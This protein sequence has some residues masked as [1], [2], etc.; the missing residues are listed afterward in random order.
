VVGAALASSWERVEA[1]LERYRGAPAQAGSHDLRVGM[2]RFLAAAEFAQL[3]EP[4]ALPDKLPSRVKRLMTALSP[5]RDIEIQR[6]ALEKRDLVPEARQKLALWL[7]Q[8]EQKLAKKVQRRLVRFPVER[9]RQGV[10]EA[11]AAL[12]RPDGDSSRSAELALLGRVAE[13]Y[14]TFDR[15]RRASH[16]HDLHEL[17]RTRV[18]FKKF[19][20]AVELAAP[21]LRSLSKPRKEALKAFQDELGALQDSVVV[22]A[23]FSRR[24]AVQP[25]ADEL[26]SEQDKLAL[27]VRAL[28]DAQIRAAVPAF[29]DYLP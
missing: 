25:L 15:R 1:E 14:R 13:R 26:R 9:T 11:V 22:L 17:H 24:K 2:R 10:A 6:E 18:A 21:L 28:L 16:D 12:G 4:E 7:R 19:R 8:H 23:L 3:L 20:Y 27:H 29:S 5:L